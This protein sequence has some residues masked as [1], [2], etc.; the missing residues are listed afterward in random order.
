M[1][2]NQNKSNPPAAR[3]W[4]TITRKVQK[5]KILKRSAKQ[6]SSM[7]LLENKFCSN[8][9]KQELAKMKTAS[10][11]IRP[12]QQHGATFSL[13]P[14]KT[15]ASFD[16]RE[17][18]IHQRLKRKRSTILASHVCSNTALPMTGSSTPRILTQ[19]VCNLPFH[20]IPVKFIV[21]ISERAPDGKVFLKAGWGLIH[22]WH[23]SNYDWML[24]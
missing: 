2:L 12:S 16:D 21:T 9:S 23:R 1:L 19:E 11:C 20:K 7:D 14:L 13:P 3:E 18:A 17:R 6:A 8:I 5:L 24:F 4:Q 22:I 10:Y 15:R